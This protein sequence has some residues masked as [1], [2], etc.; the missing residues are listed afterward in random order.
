MKDEKLYKISLLASV[1]GVMILFVFS[2]MA[3]PEPMEISEVGS[4]DVGSRVEVE[5]DVQEKYV[6]EGGHLFFHVNEEGEEINVA[7]FK[8]N[9]QK[10]NLKPK[11]IEE[12]DK[13]TVAGDVE[14]YESE[15]QILPVEVKIK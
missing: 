5:G 10:M 8:D 2:Y 13:V 4:D 14:I 12:G 15:L 7:L 9:L 1:I 11:T 6:T 3:S